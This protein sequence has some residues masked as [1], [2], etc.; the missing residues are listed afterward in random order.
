MARDGRRKSR[1]WTWA[2][3]WAS[4]LDGMLPATVCEAALA[5]CRITLRDKDAKA[6][7]GAWGFAVLTSMQTFG[8]EPTG[9]PT[10][11]RNAHNWV[12]LQAAEAA[13][14]VL[15]CFGLT[16]QDVID[17]FGM[18]G[19]GEK[20]EYDLCDVVTALAPDFALTKTAAVA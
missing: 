9:I 8:H 17:R 12:T 10:Q 15:G 1:H 4:L 6:A 7:G 3:E 11:I 16:L 18:P 19:Q 14:I 13:D 20:V 2:K 5:T